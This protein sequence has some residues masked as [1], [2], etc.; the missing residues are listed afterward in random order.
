MKGHHH[1]MVDMG[2]HRAPRSRPGRGSLGRLAEPLMEQGRG[3]VAAD[4]PASPQQGPPWHVGFPDANRNLSRFSI[5]AHH[6]G[7]WA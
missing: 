3:I 2:V 6:P 4:F 1:A 7:H 5:P